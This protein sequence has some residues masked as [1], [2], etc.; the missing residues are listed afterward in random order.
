MKKWLLID[1]DNTMMATEEHTLPSLVVRFNELYSDKIDSP[2]TMDIFN[3]HFK[4]QARQSL[5]AAL[6]HHYGIAVDYELFFANR[7]WFIMQHIQKVPDGIRMA[8]GIIEVLT[9]LQKENIFCAFV[10][11]NPI[12]RGLTSMRFAS[13]GRG[14]EL[15]KLFGTSFFESGDAQKPKPDVYLRAMAQLDTTPSQCIAIEDSASGAASA[16]T[17]GIRTLAFTGFA[18]DRTEAAKKLT[19]QGCIAAFDDWNNF[20]KLLR[21]IGA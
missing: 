15:A 16:L 11:N 7:E 17:A 20:P 19:A 21:D 14:E 18:D 5:C 3:R 2:L 12:Q 6:S 10:S 9:A 1:F 4:G 8:D 13:N